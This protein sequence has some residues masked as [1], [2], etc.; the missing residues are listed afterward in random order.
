[1]NIVYNKKILQCQ[2]VPD[3][4]IAANITVCETFEEQA[5]LVRIKDL[6]SSVVELSVLITADSEL[7]FIPILIF[8]EERNLL[9][10][11]LQN[12]ILYIDTKRKIVI[13]DIYLDFILFY[14]Y[15][16]QKNNSF[17]LVTECEILI[18][19]DKGNLLR[20]FCTNDVITESMVTDTQLRL[21]TESMNAAIDLITWSITP[22]V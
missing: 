5:F 18:F 14:V 21:K 6:F 20:S 11:G 19:D 7:S 8:Q 10:I 9:L 17:L 2:K 22:I 1:M 3:K 16:I 4:G 15:N 13:R 12:R